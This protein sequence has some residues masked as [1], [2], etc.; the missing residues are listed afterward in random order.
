MGNGGG[1][2]R[3]RRK[4]DR[5]DLFQHVD[6]RAD[7]LASNNVRTV[8]VDAQGRIWIGTSDAGVDI[9]DPA[10]GRVLQRLTDSTLSSN[11]V[12]TL[13]Q[14][15][16]GDVWIGTA[17]G[18][19][20]W[21]RESG[22]ITRLGESTGDAVLR[23]DISQVLEI[24]DGTFW[25]GTYNAGIA[26]IDR[27]GK[28]L[29]RERH[30]A[31]K[32]GSLVSDKVRALLPDADGNLW[33]GTEDG[34][35]LLESTSTHFVH[36]QHDERDPATLRASSIKSLYQDSTGLLWIGTVGGGVSRWNPRSWE[37]GGARPQWL[38]KR[39]VMGFADAPGREVWVASLAGL[40][41]YDPLT[42]MARSID[43][44]LG[45]ANALG[46][47]SVTSV[48]EAHE[49][50][51]WIGTASAG[52]KRLRSDNRVQSFPIAADKPRS[53]SAAVVTSL[54]ESRTGRIWVGT[55]GGGVNI[56]DPAT[57]DIRQLP[58]G[59]RADAVSGDR[60]IAMLE[61]THGNFW[62]G[63]EGEGLSIVDAEGRLLRT[64]RF[65]KDNRSALPSDV[66]YSLALDNEGRVWIGT[67]DGVARALDANVAPGQ[68]QVAAV[69]L[70]GGQAPRGSAYGVIGD[71]RGG[72]WISGSAGL[73]YLQTDGTTRRYHREDGLQGEEFTSGAIYRLADGRLCFGGTDGFNI[74]DPRSLSGTRAP[75]TLRLTGATVAGEALRGEQGEVPAWMLPGVSLE[76]RDNIA[77]LDFAVLDFATPDAQLSYRIVEL[78]EQWDQQGAGE[79]IRLNYLPAG[80]HTL[81]VRANADSPWSAPLRFKVHRDA[82]P[83]LRPL[84][85]TLYAVLV[86]LAIALTVRHQ[87]KKIRDIERA[88]DHLEMQVKERT[89]ELV[90]SNRQLAEAAR[91][92]GDFL[93]RMSHELR[94]PM[95]GVVGMT[96]LLSRTSL[97]S[98]QTHLTRTIRASAQILLQIVND[99]LDLSK[100]RAGT[101][102]LEA[103]TVDLGHVLE[104]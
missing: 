50:S 26:R 3:W 7:S 15:R 31:R 21:H 80:D 91:A 8:L 49:G 78:T 76:Y 69:L 16:A 71:P 93:D 29:R 37:M 39:L 20:R 36:Y 94:T 98:T 25:V 62:L 2:A 27:D 17:R 66:I 77:A 44:L 4:A 79:S 11:T 73:T 60:V 101:V 83:L 54:A 96:E 95:N 70:D 47:S 45:R 81:E 89:V 22:R 34:L 67:R 48:K 13:R 51:L 57:G 46:D 56:V 28:V 14:D 86:G 24:A 72:V 52:L 65:D 99:L 38:Q 19:D 35:D 33:V 40:F 104:E 103:L 12:F 10:S 64:F 6:G 92:K 61:D 97:S 58:Y 41:R 100:I 102:Q 82:H 18:L 1:V 43:E 90:E 9:L 74:F 87:R 88:R 85:F 53:L 5:F 23:A 75:P 55:Y 63:T 68:Q 32:P 30:D 84:A 42:G 59:A